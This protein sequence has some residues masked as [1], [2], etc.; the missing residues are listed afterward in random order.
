MLVCE[1]LVSREGVLVDGT[2]TGGVVSGTR[3]LSRLGTTLFG[4]VVD[5][6]TTVLLGVGSL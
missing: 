4:D 3:K 1:F 5:R 2:G 6:K